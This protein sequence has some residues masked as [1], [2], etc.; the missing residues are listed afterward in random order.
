MKTLMTV[1]F[2][3]VR[4]NLRDRRS[5]MNGLLMAPVF[6]P[7]LFVVLM[8]FVLQE[9]L[10]EAEKPINIAVIGAELAPNLLQ[11]FREEG[12]EITTLSRDIDPREYLEENDKQIVLVIPE[13]IDEKLRAGEV[14]V[15]PLYYDS[16]QKEADRNESR[17]SRLIQGYS[18]KIGVLRLH[19][20]GLD[21]QITRAF[22]VDD[23]D[24]ASAMSRAAMIFGMLPYFL[25]FGTIMG[26]FYLAIDTTAGER[27]RGSLETL[28][29][30]PISRTALV[31]GKVLAA[32][33]FSVAALLLTVVVFAVAFRFVNLGAIGIS[34]ELSVQQVVQIFVAILPFAVF[35]SGML[36][37]VA[38]FAKSYKEAQTYL[39][40]VILVPLIP[41]LIASVLRA[42]LSFTGSLVPAYA[43]HLIAMELI[44]GDAVP[45]LYYFTSS[46]TTIL[47]GV[48]MVGAA[49]LIYKSE[50][51]LG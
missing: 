29:S 27:E 49:T 9:E 34:T 41:V 20:R 38:A 23:I 24:V 37:L 31:T 8:Q 14:G 39:G 48:V 22:A 36:T 32:V 19:V 15:L 6:G 46:L 13:D 45:L 3:E 10:K 47:A 43:Q 40:I 44:R 33:V 1:F 26:A 35:A 50:R 51:I 18:H 7:L 17:A 2:K 16:S 4:D 25:L 42:E 5:V 11:P 30:L 12:A 21:P 28:L